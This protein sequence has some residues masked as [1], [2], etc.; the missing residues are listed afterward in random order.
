MCWGRQYRFVIKIFLVDFHQQVISR[1]FT[2]V[3]CDNA[4][5]CK[6]NTKCYKSEDNKDP[7]LRKINTKIGLAPAKLIHLMATQKQN[8]TT[9]KLLE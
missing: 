8:V 3:Y 2:L 6:E 1:Y 7:V 4:Y 5:C 9:R